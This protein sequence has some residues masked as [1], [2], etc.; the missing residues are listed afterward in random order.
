ML[1]KRNQNR[2]G[3]S[4]RKNRGQIQRIDRIPQLSVCPRITHRFRY[5][6]S[7]ALT[8]VAIT[9]T[10]LVYSIQ[11][12][13]TTTTTYAIFETVR[14]VKVEIWGPPAQD[15]VP[16]TV[17]C[18]YEGNTTIESL[19]EVYTDTSIGSTDV[20]HVKCRPS[21][22]TRAATWQGLGGTTAFYLNGPT[23][24]IVD[25][26]LE[27]TIINNSSGDTVPQAL[28]VVGATVGSVYYGRL[29]GPTTGLL[30]PVSVL[31]L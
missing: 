13:A 14:V 5:N 18:E 24:S 3:R 30:I 27:T 11:V 31:S 6:A 7:A 22:N 21:F 16:V 17:S 9:Y 19:R 29:D 20:A 4:R 10:D 1:R 28:T 25:V 2:R 15:L 12:A 26:T 23:H 8:N